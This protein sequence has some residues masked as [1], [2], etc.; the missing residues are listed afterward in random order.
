M[1]DA[2]DLYVLS[3]RYQENGLS[4]ECLEVIWEGLSHGNAIRMLMEVGGLGL[5]DLKD[6]CMSYVVLNYDKVVMNEEVLNSLSHALRGELRMIVQE[7]NMD[8]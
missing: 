1:D 2:L 3:D 4:R 8:M 5:D 6:M 7:R